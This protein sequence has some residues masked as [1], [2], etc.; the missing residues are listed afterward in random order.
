MS[1]KHD[2][3]HQS[4]RMA[5]AAALALLSGC[6]SFSPDGGFGS[7][8]QT[9]KDRLQLDVEWQ[10]TEAQRSQAEER[11]AQLLSRPLS[12][13]QAVQVALLANR[14]LQASLHEL[15]VS[16]ADA[17]SAGRLPNPGFSFGRLRRGDEI[18]IERG[19]HLNLA[20]LLT[21]PLARQVE[22][23]RWEQSRRL[24]TQQILSLAAE[25]RKAYFNAVA[26]DQ[27]VI[28]LR[29]VKEAAE[30]GSELARR[31]AQA[32][33]WSQLQQ[34]REQSFHADAVLNL[35]KAEQVRS[36]AHERLVRLVG[37]APTQGKLLLPDRLPDLPAKADELPAIE[38][39]AMDQ[40][41][42]VQAAKL[43]AEQQ[44]RNL[45]LVKATRFV[46]VLELGVVHNSS[47]EAPTQRGY[48]ISLELPL[49]DGGQA[50]TA[51]AESLYMQAV[52]LAAQTALE[53]QSEVRE[54][55]TAYRS[56]F[57]LARHYRDEIV[58]LKKRISDE[59]LLQ[60]N[61]M[62]IGVFEL[63]ADARAQIESVNAS[64]QAQR[65]FWIAR[66]DLDMALSGKVALT[67]S[68]SPTSG[69]APADSAAH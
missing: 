40:R 18:E 41:L 35:L 64:I 69:G 21:M 50:R 36:A 51:K 24:V 61:G 48:E 34:A 45:G 67:P 5:S 57:E 37:M 12:A 32:G 53:A 46:N 2:F 26:A 29:Q 39:A 55:F 49:F 52:H 31:M 19:F 10:R 8:Q 23:R 16:E 6:A 25:V 42:D 20:R 22:Q 68:A 1:Q 44:A 43:Q 30:A 7:V 54:A 47:N 62:F 56:S 14:G 17:V 3:I 65:D 27:S 33:N 38:Q 63:L 9:V 4:R 58:P 59:V 13:D 11:V 15:G 66:S 28:Y 60:Y